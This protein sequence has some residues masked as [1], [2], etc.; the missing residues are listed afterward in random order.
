MNQSAALRSRLTQ[1]NENNFEDIALEVFKFQAVQNTVY[2]KFLALTGFRPDEI[3]S[4]DNIP[5]L[6]IRFFKT[7]V[8]KTGDWPSEKI[9]R[10]SGTSETGYSY[11]HVRD[12]EFYLANAV[13][14]YEETF[15]PLKATCFLAVLP[16]Y[17]ERNDASLA[18]MADWFIKQTEIPESGFYPNDP[19]R[20]RKVIDSALEKGLQVMVL[21]VTF[22]LLDLVT[23]GFNFTGVRVME[24]GGMKGRGK[25][26]IREELHKILKDSSPLEICSEYGMT[27]LL[28]QAYARSG[29]LF[30]PGKLM[31]ILIREI[32][33]QGKKALAGATGVINII[34]LANLDTCSFIETQDLGCQKAAGF[35]VLGRLDYSDL[36]GCS[37]MT[38]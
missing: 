22:A 20:L 15:G 28:S 16:S 18:A 32:N 34:D 24:T 3:K 25:E 36:R 35:E 19:Y 26:L 12:Q 31:R 11:H 2:S 37:L 1:I 8:I 27:E 38:L 5:F 14:N 33:D 23:G 10:S 17:T 4:I 9:F 30:R 21:G 29:G 7:Q 13:M 6:P